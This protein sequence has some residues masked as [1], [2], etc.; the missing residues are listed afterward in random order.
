MEVRE[1]SEKKQPAPRGEKEEN[2]G[3]LPPVTQAD[4]MS[5]DP[6]NENPREEN[7]D[8]QQERGVRQIDEACHGQSDDRGPNGGRDAEAFPTELIFPS[9]QEDQGHRGHGNAERH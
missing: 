3:E 6:E 5:D 9:P 1:A 8:A 4:G 2:P 7:P